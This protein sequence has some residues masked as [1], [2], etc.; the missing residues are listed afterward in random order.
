MVPI[1]IFVYN[2][3]YGGVT[4][5][6]ERDNHYVGYILQEDC[7]LFYD[8]CPSI[9]PVLKEYLTSKIDGDVSLLFYF[10]HDDHFPTVGS[11]KKEILDKTK[12]PR[13]DGTPVDVSTDS[14][15][16]DF[17]L[18]KALS[19]IQNEKENTYER[20]KGKSYRRKNTNYSKQNCDLLSTN[21]KVTENCSPAQITNT[22]SSR[23]SYISV[24][25]KEAKVSKINC[26]PEP[27]K[28][29]PSS[30]ES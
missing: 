15:S 11:K 19:E 4:S 16:S 6:V 8:G 1:E 2:E 18:A 7:F 23:T 3:R 17:L 22:R 21:T 10:P 5:F 25:S 26:S 13:R 14:S 24:P 30:S 28:P 20:P 9:N 27:C 29:S 12:S